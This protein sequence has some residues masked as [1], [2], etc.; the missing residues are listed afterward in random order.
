[1]PRPHFEERAMSSHS[2][3]LR[4]ASIMIGIGIGFATIAGSHA[5]EA[6]NT[7]VAALG[8]APVTPGPFDQVDVDKLTVKSDF[9]IFMRPDC[10]PALRQKALQRLWKLL[11][12]ETVVDNAPF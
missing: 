12:A 9:S 11:P 4:F 7:E 1:M 10:P 8:A 3:R 2:K 6:Q 5:E